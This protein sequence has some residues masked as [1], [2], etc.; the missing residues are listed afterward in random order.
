MSLIHQALKQEQDR[1]SGI[2]EPVPQASTVTRYPQAR[3]FHRPNNN[4]ALLILLCGGGIVLALIITSA[5]YF[6]SDLMN[7]LKSS[8]FLADNSAEKAAAEI[9]AAEPEKTLSIPEQSIEAS[10]AAIQE[11]N[12]KAL[13]E[14][15]KSKAYVHTPANSNPESDPA[16]QA[17]VESLVFH[18]VRSA[19]SNSRLLI[20]GRVYRIGDI[21]EPRYGLKF[22]GIRSGKVVFKDKIG[23]SYLRHQ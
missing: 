13:Q 2:P 10:K 15:A 14:D 6:G 19:G 9:T 16:I 11:I 20:S 17:Y 1:R 18:G 21:L 5:I 3:P 23:A 4:S 8:S 22:T 12:L 7:T